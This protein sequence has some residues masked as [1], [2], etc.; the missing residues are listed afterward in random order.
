M[1]YT[2]SLENPPHPNDVAALR[3]GLRQYNLAHVPELVPLPA[4]DIAVVARND[5]GNII[6]GVVGNA[7]WGWFFVDIVWVHET[8]RGKGLGSRLMAVMERAVYEQGVRNIYLVTTSFQALPFYQKLGYD[9]WG[10]LADR[11]RGYRYYY[12]KKEN[13]EAAYISHNFEIEIPPLPADH[14]WLENALLAYI[15]RYRPVDFVPL[16]VMV[17]EA[18]AQPGDGN[19][20]G[21]I[22]GSTYWDW[23]DLSFMWVSESLRGTG[24][25]SRL[26]AL[27]EEECIRRGVYH[28][29]CDTADFQA[30]PFYQ[31]HGFEVFGTLPNRPP[32]HTSFYLRK[33]IAAP[34]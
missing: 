22:V 26:L 23:F 17:R 33:S 21:G 13:L 9:L 10:E 29:T 15:A 27:A 34:G 6:G 4:P 25:G 7:D 20:L 1:S 8:Q 14:E 3:A 5:I 18:G 2:L 32:G 24:L 30:L 31:K 11:P 16:V 12:L 19:V 28:V